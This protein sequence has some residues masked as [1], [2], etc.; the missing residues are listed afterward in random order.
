MTGPRFDT[1]EP[2]PMKTLYFPNRKEAQ[3][4]M[5][6]DDPLL[7]L[8]SYDGSQILLAPIDQ[9]FE[10]LIL[11]KQLGFPEKDIDKYFRLVV[12]KSGADWTF[13]CPSDYRNIK[14]KQRRI[15]CFY[16]DG[17]K[18]IPG[19]LKKIGYDVPL[20]IPKRFRRH[21]TMLKNGDT[22]LE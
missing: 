11:L 4:V 17:F 19:T 6:Q 14:D 22:L 20:E 21:F 15:E 1:I 9:S 3:E 13:V 2:F 16:N 5:K 12:N 7:I 10:H 18:I 8:V